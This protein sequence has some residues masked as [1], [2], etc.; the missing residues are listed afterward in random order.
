MLVL[1]TT[2]RKRVD[3]VQGYNITAKSLEKGDVVITKPR[4]VSS[5]LPNCKIKII[6]GYK[7]RDIRMCD[8]PIMYDEEN[9]EFGSVLVSDMYAVKRDNVWIPI[10]HDNK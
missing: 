3:M 1:E 7:T 9:R 6:D 8:V 2:T 4:G 10:Q 5:V